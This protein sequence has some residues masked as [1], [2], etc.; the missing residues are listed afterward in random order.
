MT[1]H[2]AEGCKCASIDFLFSNYLITCN[3]TEF[4][5]TVKCEM[6]CILF[7]CCIL[8][9]FKKERRHFLGV[10]IHTS[11]NPLSIHI[12]TSAL[13]FTYT[14]RMHKINKKGRTVANVT[15]YNFAIFPF[16]KRNTVS[17]AFFKLK[18]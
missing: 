2:S 7:Q 4:H 14:Y 1:L 6:Q 5:I 18:T 16:F 8:F 10:S 12:P 17:I 15:N 3:A 11:F 13:I 9:R